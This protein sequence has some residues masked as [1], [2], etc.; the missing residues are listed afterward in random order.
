MDFVGDSGQRT[1]HQMPDRG[2]RYG[3]PRCVHIGVDFGISGRI[4]H[5][6]AGPAA[7]FRG[8]RWP[9]G[10]T[11]GGSSPARRPPGRSE[12][13]VR[14]PPI[15]PGKPMQNGY[16]ELQRQVPRRV[17]ERALVPD[18]QQARETIRALATR[19]QR[20][21][22]AQQ[23]RAHPACALRR[24]APPACRRCC[25][26]EFNHQRDHV[27]FN[28]DSFRSTGTAEGQRVT[29]H[30]GLTGGGEENG[31][32]DGGTVSRRTVGACCQNVTSRVTTGDPN[33]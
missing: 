13:H 11:T 4:R 12:H 3:Q 33:V 23:H 10:P 28:P 7:R 6:T 24:A 2:R 14:I 9:F 16:I 22:T 32:D 26:H 17:P 31:R 5:S 19:L 27:T 18:L 25:S 15:E 8:Y 1:A 21:S 20:G 30:N 29:C